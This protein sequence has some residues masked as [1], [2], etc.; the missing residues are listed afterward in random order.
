MWNN[1]CPVS[2]GGREREGGG[3][4]GGEVGTGHINHNFNCLHW[5]HV[6][7]VNG[8]SLSRIIDPTGYARHKVIIEYVHCTCTCTLLCT[9]YT[10]YMYVHVH[11]VYMYTCTNV[12]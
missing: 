12:L 10:L 4:G 11:T 6:S 3:G 8:M 9:L 1:G 5:F 7:G 2:N